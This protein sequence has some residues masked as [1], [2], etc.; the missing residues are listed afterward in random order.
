MSFY[1]TYQSCI[2]EDV[3][4]DVKNTEEVGKS[5]YTAFTERSK[6]DFLSANKRKNHSVFLLRKS[7]RKRV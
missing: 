3:I 2:S 5:Q 7:R 1:S 4:K 6:S